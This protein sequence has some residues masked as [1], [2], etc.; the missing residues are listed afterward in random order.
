[1]QSVKICVM[2]IWMSVRHQLIEL[3]KDNREEWN[4]Q[5]IESRRTDNEYLSDGS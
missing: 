1:M 4:V 3:R 5:D 2:I